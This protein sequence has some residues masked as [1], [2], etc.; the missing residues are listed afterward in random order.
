[1][2]EVQVAVLGQREEGKAMSVLVPT[3]CDLE[4][5]I[6]WSAMRDLLLRGLSYREIAVCAGISTL[7]ACHL[8]TPP[9]SVRR[10]VRARADGCCESCGVSTSSGHFHHDTSCSDVSLFNTAQAIFYF[11]PHCHVVCHQIL[12]TSNDVAT[13]RYPQ[14]RRPEGSRSVFRAGYK[15]R[16]ANI[17]KRFGADAYRRWGRKGGNPLL[18]AQRDRKLGQGGSR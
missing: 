16:T 14:S 11:C 15:R 2:S 1:M 10:E 7:R 6:E 3:I 5:R 18:L 12:A 4:C 17:R 9:L 13:H 8:L